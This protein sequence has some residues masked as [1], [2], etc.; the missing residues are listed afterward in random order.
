MMGL[1]HNWIPGKL[2]A[3]RQDSFWEG[4]TQ[5]AVQQMSSTNFFSAEFAMLRAQILLARDYDDQIKHVGEQIKLLN[6]VKKLYRE[7]LNLI[8]GT[9]AQKIQ[10]KDKKP[11]IK[12]TPAQAADVLESFRTYHYNLERP[13]DE[14]VSEPMMINDSGKGH[15]LDGIDIQDGQVVAT[16]YIETFEDLSNLDGSK[17]AKDLAKKMGGDKTERMFYIDKEKDWGKDGVPKVCFYVDAMEQYV[18]IIN[19]KLKDVEADAE[20]MGLKLDQLTSKRKTALDL[21]S[22]MI[23]KLDEVRT[24]SVSKL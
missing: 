6:K 23:H 2:T 24:N 12:L 8:N 5:G 7:N 4:P 10:E 11:I 15:E 19:N 1:D 22:Q 14:I 21:V 20:E 17:E 16:D 9:M 3:S 13:Q 18:E